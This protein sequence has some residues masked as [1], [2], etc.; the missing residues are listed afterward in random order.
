MH[1]LGRSESEENQK[2]PRLPG[3]L[4]RMIDQDVHNLTDQLNAFKG[5]MGG[6][7]TQNLNSKLECSS[8]PGY[9]SDQSPL[10]MLPKG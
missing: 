10:G 7:A 6:T 9:L 4:K 1:K 3:I 5:D 8:G 2:I